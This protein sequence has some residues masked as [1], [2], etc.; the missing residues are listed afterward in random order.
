MVAAEQALISSYD[1]YE[2]LVKLDVAVKFF[3]L[4]RL[5]TDLLLLLRQLLRFLLEFV[6]D[7]KLQG[8]TALDVSQSYGQQLFCDQY[9]RLHS[10]ILA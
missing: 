5:Y 10:S 9:L 7:I 2:Y 4:F 1:G 6:L 3:S 8:R